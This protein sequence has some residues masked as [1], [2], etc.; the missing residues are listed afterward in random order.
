MNEVQ[1]LEQLKRKY[2]ADMVSALVG[3]GFTQNA[4]PKAQTW[5][6]ML[7]DLVE[8]AYADELEGMYQEY[9]HR[10]HGIDVKPF[11]DMKDGFV[12][13]IVGR[14][15]YLDVVS[16]YIQ[17][18]GYREAMDYY[19][20]THNPYFYRRDDGTFGV[21]G[22]DETV[23]ADKNFTVHQ[24]FLKGKWQYVFTTNFDNALE[25]V[26]EQF[27]M[28]FQT[29]YS[30]YE[31]SRRKMARPI[32]KIHGSLVPPDR[33]LTE[34]YLF[35]GDHSRRY[36]ISR[37]DFETYAKRHE[38]FS[39]LLKVAMLSG[40]YLLLGFSGDDP[41][42]Q[43]WL[44]WVKDII[45]KDT[46]TSR[47]TENDGTPAEEIVKSDEDNIKVFLV[48]V[49]D[50][51]IPV[52]RRL[53]YR[54]HHIG[55]IHLG[56]PDIMRV[57]HCFPNTPVNIRI[58]HLLDHL[59]GSGQDASTE[60]QG[61][62][63]P[64]ISLMQRWRELYQYLRDN[65]PIDDTVSGIRQR[66]LE[67]CFQKT[68]PFHEFVLRELM[69]HEANL[70][71][72]EKEILP[73]LIEDMGL[74]TRQLG[75]TVDAQMRGSEAWPIFRQHE[76]T[77]LGETGKLEEESDFAIHEN[78]QR[79]LYRFDFAEARHLMAEW[80]PRGRFKVIKSS[81]NYFYDRNDS[82]Q[83]LDSLIMNTDSD[84]EKYI[85]SF[86]YNCIDGGFY[87]RY[88]LN[89][90][91][92]R[93]IV[94]LND[95][96]IAIMEQMKARKLD[97][98][99]YGSET[100]VMHADGVDPA[101]RME[102]ETAQRFLQLITKYGFNLCYGISNIVKITDW[103]AVF[104]RVY[105]CLPYPCLYYSC[106]YNNRNV[107]QRI[108]QDYAFEPLLRQELPLLLHQIFKAL[109]CKDTPGVMLS[110]MLQVGS[111]MFFGMKEDAWFEDFDC[112]LRDTYVSEDGACLHSRYARTFV[113]YALLGLHDSDH[114]SRILTTL[115]GYFEQN[116]SEAIDQLYYLRLDKLPG[117]TEEHQ[118]HLEK[119]VGEGD[120]SHLAALLALMHEHHLLQENLQKSFLKTYVV[121][122]DV[123][124]E[125]D[126]YAFYNFCKLAEE[127]LETVSK[128][129]PIILGRNI[130]NCGI[131][132]GSF[133]ETEQF[134]LMDLNHEMYSWTAEELVLIYG[135]MKENLRKIKQKT[136]EEDMFFAKGFI[137]LLTDMLAFADKYPSV[138]EGDVRQ[139]VVDKLNSARHYNGIE[140]G[141]YN[142][143]PDAVES[144]CRELNARFRQGI[145]DENIPYFDILLSKCAMKNA[146]GLSDCLVTVS[147]AV[148]F[149]GEQIRQHREY[150]QMLYRL[151]LQYEGK[152][153]RDLD[154]QI[155]NASHALFEIA[156]YLKESGLDDRH[157]TWWTENDNLKRLNF[158]DF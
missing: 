18:K 111:Q 31:M 44:E 8:V 140:D 15:G 156:I 94:G 155:I 53:Y 63:V 3:S 5:A 128:L 14:D 11:N 120:F 70:S 69:R 107:L 75:E 99:T 119:I 142:E 137:S 51:E 145:F 16:R 32:V 38:A 158:V 84:I 66:R 117:L 114:I 123:L 62:D 89:D 21:K 118:C 154:L 136:L 116:P 105:T 130:W 56:N 12:K 98:N 101:I 92:N 9:V 27:N 17:K 7:T 37:E 133:S 91:R 100:T 35:D 59:I 87:P 79:T 139:E 39:Y 78:I 148:H 97:L 28:G 24:R 54:N 86:Y 104:R 147:V 138:V 73:W 80:I 135:N 19:I 67:E 126:R 85:A 102:S 50:D 93:G 81:L 76:E 151:L 141:L 77:L 34:P 83:Q 121:R 108:G 110:G 150:S 55:I 29:I 71:D 95:T 42:F 49:D 106:Q 43:S 57:L 41:N 144:A 13:K 4:Y 103:Y 64:R 61:D 157:I 36:V 40:S 20:E 1:I 132:N 124:N 129:K 60:L 113:M 122:E 109:G 153:L 2:D 46:R 52:E 58:D 47:Y 96:I 72:A 74:F 152:D 23:L 48:L 45:D 65:K 30:D 90:F 10:R 127:S 134:F 33:T 143:N 6:N 115:L 149:C 25:F 26:N 131:T 82:L 88:P 125:A 68:L 22:D 112:Y 146:P